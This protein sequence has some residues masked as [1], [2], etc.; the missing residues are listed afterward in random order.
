MFVENPKKISP[1]ARQ[2]FKLESVPQNTGSTRVMEEYDGMTFA[3]SKPE[4]VNVRKTKAGVGYTKMATLKRIGV[5]IDI[6]Y[7]MR[8][9]G[10]YNK[11]KTD[12]ID[13]A[14]FCTH[15]QELDLSHRFTFGSAT[16]YVNMD[17]ETVDI[18]TGDN[19]S[20]INNAKTLPFSP[21]TYS[22][23]VS[24]DPVFSQSALETA[25]S[26]TNTDILSLFGEKRVMNFDT[27]VTSDHTP[28]VN[29][30]KVLLQATA[31]ISAPNEGVPNVYES[32]Y[33]HVILPYLAT[34]ATGA[35]DNAKKNYWFILSSSEWNGYLVEWEAERLV[36]PSAGNNMEDAHAD[37]WSYGVRSGYDI[38]VVSG[39]GVIGSLNNS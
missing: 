24:G 30:V 36:L 28:V 4:G 16:S 32:R 6:T 19:L 21:I 12:L 11:I 9:T 34:T 15:R 14:N 31:S 20:L 5:E 18:T 13:L 29:A 7:E 22:N 1:R 25:D 8:T 38:V 33:N 39:R 10:K 37:V 35:R 26:I 17:G 3:R 27:I 2:L 23:R